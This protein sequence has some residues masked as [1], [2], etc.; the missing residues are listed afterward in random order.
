MAPPAH[1]RLHAHRISA[2][3]RRAW[4]L[5]V[6]A[7]T[8][9]LLVAC[10]AGQITQTDTQQAAINGTNAE[11][12][13]LLL[14][15]VYFKAE[16]TDPAVPRYGQVTLAFTVVNQSSAPDRLVSIDSPAGELTLE[17]SDQA[18]ELLPGSSLSAG[19]PIE[20]LRPTTAPDRP[21]TVRGRFPAEAIR[22]G[23]THPVTFTFER[24]GTVTFE[25]PFDAWTPN[26]P[27]PTERPLPPLPASP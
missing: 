14:R 15:N 17:A 4:S 3:H 16:P 11:L 27:L 2:A 21:L 8:A 19:E 9:L 5:L 20:Q 13:D 7:S 26:E 10:G 18:R 12:G 6:L 24:A 1:R 23:L 22:P 25:V